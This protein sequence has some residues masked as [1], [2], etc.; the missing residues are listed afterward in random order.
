M[1]PLRVL[2]PGG[3]AQHPWVQQRRAGWEGGTTTRFRRQEAPHRLL[4]ST[5]WPA[6]WAR[7]VQPPRGFAAPPPRQRVDWQLGLSPGVRIPGGLAAPP[8]QALAGWLPIPHFAAHP[9]P[10]PPLYLPSSFPPSLPRPQIL[11]SSSSPAPALGAV[12]V[13]MELDAPEKWLLPPQW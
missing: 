5:G 13:H 7:P 12:A 2:R 9:H 10:H 8:I 1:L 3:S 6:G 4:L 11:D